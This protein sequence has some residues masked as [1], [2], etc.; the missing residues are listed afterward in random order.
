MLIFVAI[1]VLSKVAAIAM[2]C[3]VKA[4]GKDFECFSNLNRSQIAT[5]SSFS[6]LSSWK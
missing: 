1:S 3:S 5:S 6:F 2:Q 4:N